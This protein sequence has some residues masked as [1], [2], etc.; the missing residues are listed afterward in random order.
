MIVA[1]IHIRAHDLVGVAPIDRIILFVALQL[2]VVD[3]VAQEGHRHLQLSRRHE[4]ARLGHCQESETSSMISSVVSSNNILIILLD[5]VNFSCLFPELAI[6]AL[7]VSAISKP[8][9][10]CGGSISLIPLARIQKHLVLH[11]EHLIVPGSVVCHFLKVVGL[12]NIWV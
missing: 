5:V 9:F 12:R 6:A 10:H 3:V 2:A 8:L 11:R 1:I 7:K 4:V